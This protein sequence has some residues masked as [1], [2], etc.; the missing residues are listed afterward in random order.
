MIHAFCAGLVLLF[1]ITG[2][3]ASPKALKKRD[4]S[5]FEIQQFQKQNRAVRLKSMISIP[6]PVPAPERPYSELEPAGYLFFSSALNFDS[7]VAKQVL[8]KNLPPDVTLV[9][10][11]GTGASKEAVIKSYRGV[12]EESRIKVVEL[13]NAAAGFWARDGLPIPIW[14]QNQ[15]MDLVDAKYYHRFEPDQEVSQWFESTLY[16]HDYYFE[17]GNFVTNELGDCLT[18][19]NRLS[20]EIPDSIFYELYGCKKLLRFPHRKGIGHADESMKF[21]DAAT[22]LTDDDLYA[23]TLTDAGYKVLRVPRPARKFET[24]VNSL[25]VNGT[26]YVPVFNQAQDQQVIKLYQD[27]GFKVVPIE[28]IS[29]SNDGNGSLH[30]ITMTYPKV[31]FDSLL[32]SFGG[33]EL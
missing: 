8:A 7:K 11:V 12:I 13:P 28:T 26:M 3:A 9:I 1:A 18:I 16:N 17:G 33:R 21:L 27:A 30:C 10:F 29:L 14:G 20:K 4:L 23:Q 22:V 31:P 6:K 25:L 32:K 2:L 5:S 19:D 15:K 24:Y